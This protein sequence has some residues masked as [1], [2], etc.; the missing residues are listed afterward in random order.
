[1]LVFPQLSTGVAG[2]FPLTR[3]EVARTVVNS[4]LD[5]RTVRYADTGWPGTQW[6]LPAT[7]LAAGEWNAIEALFQATEGR[8]ESFVFLDPADNLLSWSEDLSNAAWQKDAML[9]VTAGIADPLGT[10]RAVRVTNTGQA[11][12]RLTQQ[13][14]VPGWFQY[15]FSVEAR[16]GGGSALTMIRA[17]AGNS[18]A[19]TSSLSGA[20]TRIV[21][22]GKFTNTDESIQFSIELA[23]G[24]SVDLFG[25]QV[26]AQPGASAYKK[27]TERSGVYASARFLD[28]RLVVTAQGKDRMDAVIRVASTPQG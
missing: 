11:A 3:R 14:A 12:Q 5:G 23:A 24:A 21:S 22:S 6:D 20:W 9:Q 15:C 4:L 27:T 7:A 28:D 8:L 16:S 17:T 25:L 19:Q 26:E 18:Q 2:Q 13:L 10:S 1:M